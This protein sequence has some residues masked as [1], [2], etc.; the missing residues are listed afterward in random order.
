M[1][2]PIA[3]CR[4]P[5]GVV[6][7]L[8]FVYVPAV[9]AQ[10]PGPMPTPAASPTPLPAP[11]PIKVITKEERAQIDGAGDSKARVRTTLDL[12]ALR[13]TR[14]E[15]LA[16]QTNYD[17][18]LAEVGSYEALIQDILDFLNGMKRDSNKTRD[19]CKRVELALRAHGPR[20]TTMRRE[21]PLEFAV[22]IKKSEEFARSARTEVLNTF[23]GHTVVR[24]SEKNAN[25]P[26]QE[27]PKETPTP[28]PKSDQPL[29]DQP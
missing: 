3:N 4:L 28:T 17:D 22:W 27:K 29:R 8:V 11:P 14:A 25:T 19:L 24:D 16:K 5:I 10:D 18:A 2:L 20:L 1:K 7:L 26:P 15:Q 12:A 9:S 6:L 23:Y 21:T 13:L